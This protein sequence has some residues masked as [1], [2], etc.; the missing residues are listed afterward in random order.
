MADAALTLHSKIHKF[1]LNTSIGPEC[2]IFALC[3]YMVFCT[4]YVFT[5]KILNTCIRI[6]DIEMRD[7]INWLIACSGLTLPEIEERAGITAY[8][9][10]NLLT[11]KRRV[12]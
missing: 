7:R 4:D 3:V 12:S 1:P 2:Y 9:W 11:G 8:T 6:F 5:Y 10:G